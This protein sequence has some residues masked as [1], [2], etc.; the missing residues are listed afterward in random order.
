MKRWPAGTGPGA[1]GQ[2]LKLTNEW[3]EV[4]GIAKDVKNRSLSETPQPFLYLPVLQDYCS[5]MILVARTA[6]NPKQAFHGVQTEVA[7]LGAGMPM[8]DVKTLEEHIG[9]SL[10]STT[11]GSNPA[12]HFRLWARFLSQPWDF[13]A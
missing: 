4:V 3:L 7:A 11:H 8:F 13:T 10:F 9:V 1:L 12:E 2:R 5:N 6:M